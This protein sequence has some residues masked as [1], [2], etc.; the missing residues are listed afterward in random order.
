MSILAKPYD[1]YVYDDILKDGSF[2]EVCLGTIGSDKML[3]PNRALEPN[4]VRNIN[5]QKSFSFKMYKKYVDP[6]TGKRVLNPFTDWLIN[7]RK[8]KVRIEEADGVE[9]HDFII[10]DV[11]ENSSNYLYTYELE[12][13]I[14]Q[15][16]SKNGFG[17]TLDAQLNNNIGT[18]KK[19]AESV[20]AETDWTVESEA[21]VQKV[22]EPLVYVKL[23]E[24]LTGTK[25]YRI[26][27]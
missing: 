8:V 13:A 25:I 3:G 24:N 17:K 22:E 27:D 15:E 21:L 10:K 4:L 9:W 2:K 12:D 16:L 7:E 11:K 20:L 5:G 18:A 1:I 23:P 6:I 14:V 19:L 26:K